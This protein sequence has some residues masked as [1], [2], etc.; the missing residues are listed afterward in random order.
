MNNLL[1]DLRFGLRML[2]KTP[3][4][5]F[6]A[7]LVLALSIGGTS[8]MFT[9]I[10][11]IAFR[12]LAVKS[13]E[14]LVRVYNKE[15]KPSGNYRSFSYADFIELRSQ[16]NV[17]NDLTGFTMT[18]VGI[19]EGDLTSR[20]F[21]ALV[22]ANYFSTFGIPMK[23]GRVFL[24]E[25]EKPG[26]AIPVVIVSYAFWQKKGA[27]P[28]FV[29]KNLRINSRSFQVVGITPEFF[30]GTSAM[31]SFDF[32][33]PLGMY[34]Q[35][36]NLMDEKKEKLDDRQNHCLMLLGRLKP[37]LT[38]ASA[39]ARLQPPAAE[40][41]KAHP[42]LNKDYSLEVGESPRISINTTPVKDPSAVTLTVLLM[43][44]SGAVLLIASLNLANMLLA[45]GAARKQEIA[46]RLSLGAG[47]AR[48]VRQLL[49]EG[50]LL[51]LLG[52]AGGLV[53]AN[54]TTR[55]LVASI[56][57]R[58]G[59]LSVV[60]DSRPDWRVLIIT[61]MFCLISVLI[62]CL[63]PSLRL[64]RT[65]VTN[66]LK[67]KVGDELRGK[68]GLSLFAPRSLLIIAQLALSLA[69]LTAAGL[70]SH[71]AIKA[72]KSNPGFTYDNKIIVETDGRL[73]GYDTAHAKRA[74]LELLE[75]L[76][77][78]PGVESASLAYLVPFSSFSD[79]CTV[80]KPGDS[81]SAAGK[82]KSSHEPPCYAGFNIISTDYPKTLGLP[83]QRGRD[84]DAVEVSAN[85]ASRVAIIDEPLAAKLWNGENPVGRQ[86]MLSGKEP[87]LEIVGVVAGVRD[88]LD[89]KAPKPHVYVPFGQDYRSAVNLHLRLRPM[90]AAAESAMLATVRQLIRS[91]D[92]HLAVISIQSFHQFHRDGVLLWFKK[93][94]ARV[95]CV[96]GFLALFLAVVGMYGVKA[97]VVARRTREIGIRMALGAT[98]DKVLWMVLKEGIILAVVGLSLGL[99][100]ALVVGLLLRSMIYEVQAIDPL[101]FIGA[102]LCLAITT[103]LACYLPA[104]R[105]TKVQPMAAL[106]YE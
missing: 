22:T 95:F 44:M 87:V 11:A 17:F 36:G 31:F 97:Y 84:F 35:L 8:A 103:L 79:G 6:V 52:G 105:A 28:D 15:Q 88:D 27:D 16:N 58:L 96:F 68:S 59:M 106:R 20:S 13:P 90:G 38:M 66:D 56:T 53:L 75:R 50:L 78:L 19:T 54:W 26:S 101:T 5:T 86:I 43:G 46:I 32:W 77:A 85:S 76:R 51:S 42:D 93:T 71:A 41:A 67:E 74:Y 94:A 89:D 7:V 39:Q 69:L 9:L 4:F 81:A 99:L 92:S 49:T 24:P 55:I 3:G 10:N 40:M 57:P 23:A 70:F 30:S 64:S 29:G 82:D 72:S 48:L 73:G 45:R 60:F 63:G 62:F 25:E 14:Q 1:Q 18:M 104:R 98:R 83:L 61:F 65:S 12:P 37:G 33:L 91:F 47:R 34:D 80:E 100:L 2:S 102:P 21:A